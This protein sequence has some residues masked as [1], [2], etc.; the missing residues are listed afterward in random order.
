MVFYC[1]KTIHRLNSKDR[2]DVAWTEKARA[3]P[4]YRADGPE[5]ALDWL[6]TT[7]AEHLGSL[8]KP[9]LIRAGHDGPERLERM[10]DT[11][12]FHLERGEMAGTILPGG[13]GFAAHIHCVPGRAPEGRSPR[14]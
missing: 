11:W 8:S 5:D 4:D 10:G 14:G 9:Q 13:D 3:H 6:E 1:L 12:R 7:V 2:F